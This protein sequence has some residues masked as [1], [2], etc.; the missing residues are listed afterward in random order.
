MLKA[1]AQRIRFS[2]FQRGE[3]GLARNP[4]KLLLVSLSFDPSQGCLFFRYSHFGS[5]IGSIF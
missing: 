4:N 1:S 5:V 2:G 3:E